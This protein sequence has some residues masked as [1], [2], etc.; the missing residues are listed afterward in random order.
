MILIL[1]G[2]DDFSLTEHL[3]HL[4]QELGEPSLA[5]AN[6]TRLEGRFSARELAET[7]GASP[8]FISRRLVI[9]AGLLGR[10][11]PRGERTPGEAEV[12]AFAEALEAVPETTLLVLLEETV[13]RDNPL[14]NKLRGRA[15]VRE[16]PSPR[17][18][19]LLMWIQRRVE[20]CGGRIAPRAVGLLADA[21]GDNLWSLASEVDKLVLY[22]GGEPI[23]EDM[24]RQ[25]ASPVREAN[26]FRL[27]E[28]LLQGRAAGAGQGLHHLLDSGMRPGQILGFMAQQ[29]RR[30]I[31]AQ[32]LLEQK[33]PE[34]EV[35]LRLN[36]HHPYALKQT[37]SQARQYPFHRLS[38]AM[39]QLLETDLAIK[40][41]RW[42]ERLAVDFLIAGL[43]P[44]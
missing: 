39:G 2:K 29:F 3:R 12:G 13:K 41:G 31:L 34:K 44:R 27:T 4:R 26:M 25:V 30:L 10:F 37:I 6:T 40:T 16:F 42:D 43:C 20:Q 17:G 11:E 5:E 7:C 19:D 33:V 23:N 38:A 8:F 36:I 24:V 18:S 32:E 9:A 15:E 1:W 22:S 14:F 28:S 21:V 35:G